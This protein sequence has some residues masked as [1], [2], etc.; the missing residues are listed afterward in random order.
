[1]ETLRLGSL[2]YPFCLYGSAA[3]QHGT[4]RKCQEGGDVQY[5]EGGH[6]RSLLEWVFRAADREEYILKALEL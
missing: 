5:T 1:M 4:V 6:R 3:R 2:L